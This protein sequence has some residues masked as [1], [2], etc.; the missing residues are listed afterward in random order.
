MYEI[1]PCPICGK[2]PKIKHRGDYRVEVACKPLFKKAHL[3]AMVVNDSRV[4][5]RD[6]I[7]VWNK[8][9]SAF[10][11]HQKEQA[12]K[13]DSCEYDQVMLF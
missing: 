4:Y 7:D 13:D 12:A 5:A 1:Q 3:T 10:I 9:V 11:K 6:V 2:Y 8:K